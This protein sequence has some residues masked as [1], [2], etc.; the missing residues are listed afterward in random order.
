[1]IL[2]NLVVKNGSYTDRDGKDRGRYVVI[3]QLH[4]G[5]DGGQ[6]V[7][8][9]AHVNLAAFPRRDGDTRVMVSLYDPKPRDVP[10]DKLRSASAPEPGF[11]DEI[12]F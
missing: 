12:P 9:D 5:K 11:D 1:M 4:D 10:P 2:K 3:G 7:T 8:L 6:Y